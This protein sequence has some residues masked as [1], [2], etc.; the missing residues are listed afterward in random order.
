[1]CN[2]K[3][4][5]LK[6]P[7]P[8]VIVEFQNNHAIITESNVAYKSVITESVSY[9][10]EE[11]I[12]DCIVNSNSR[13]I[14]I[15]QN[16]YNLQIEKID[17][18]KFSVWFCKIECNSKNIN[19]K[20]STDITNIRNY[21]NWD[22]GEVMCFISH[23]IKNPLNMILATMQL[24]EKKAEKNIYPKDILQHVELVKRNSFRIMKIVNDLSSK[25]KIELG[26]E[27]F[28]PTNQDIVYF[29][30]DICES[31][32]DFV[33][34]NEMNIIFDTDIEELVVGFD[35]EKIEKI[36]L[37]LI[38]NSL[39]FRKKK[40]GIVLVSLS[41]DKD[42]VYIKVKDNGIGISKENAKRIFKIFERVNDKRSIVKQGTGVGLSLVKTFAK[43][44]NGSV[45]VK[46]K[47][48]QGS[49]FTVKIANTLT[50]KDE[51]QDE[52]EL[53]K[54]ERIQNIRVAF[55]DLH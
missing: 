17:E 35:S 39:K 15:E 27:T 45:S 13:Q 38:S 51:T 9:I 53:T 47:L 30:E 20:S 4:I 48:G 31:V 34:I 23:E 36:V 46:S 52:Y 26:Y 42:F 50:S 32:R 18:C 49:E 19:E 12:T 21:Y 29:V 11:I 25:S 7:T 10:I 54:D 6:S 14:K 44:H 43:L 41:H 2:Y 33:N 1:M 22:K 55:S 24:I 8:L 16:F 3:N 40:D 5:L 37:N 28:N